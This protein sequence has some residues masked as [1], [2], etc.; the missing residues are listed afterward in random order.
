VNNFL[1][2]NDVYDVYYTSRNGEQQFLHPRRKRKVSLQI[3][4][5]G[6]VWIFHI[7]PYFAAH[8]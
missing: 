5:F 8:L 7:L 1:S 6:G 4:S 3:M 2:D